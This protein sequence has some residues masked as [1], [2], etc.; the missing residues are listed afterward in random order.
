MSDT[1]TP[2][3]VLLTADRPHTQKLGCV[4]AMWI[5]VAVLAAVFT[6][7]MGWMLKVFAFQY[8]APVFWLGMGAFLYW[9][10]TKHKWRTKNDAI[11]QASLELSKSPIAYGDT[12]TVD[13]VQRVKEQC[14]IESVAIKLSCTEDCVEGQSWDCLDA[15][16]QDNVVK[17][18]REFETEDA[19]QHRFEIPF[20]QETEMSFSIPDQGKIVMQ[21][22]NWYFEVTTCCEGRKDVTSNYELTVVPHSQ[23]TWQEDE[24]D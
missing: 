17:L 5:P 21:R 11:K 14:R 20:P 24:D 6:S 3:P 2:R 12:L 18:D 22:F 4:S 15:Y 23:T 19:I 1:Q 16:E 7:W 9:H 8:V 10:D 13:F